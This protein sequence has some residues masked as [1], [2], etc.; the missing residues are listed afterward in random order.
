[1]FRT[2]QG[3]QS[4]MLFL[5]FPEKT[6]K[7]MSWWL[8]LQLT[9]SAQCDTKWH[10]VYLTRTVDVHYIAYKHTFLSGTYIS[11]LYIWEDHFPQKI[12]PLHISPRVQSVDFHVDLWVLGK[13]TLLQWHVESTWRDISPV[14]FQVISALAI[15]GLPCGKDS[16]LNSPEIDIAHPSQGL[17]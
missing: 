15:Q 4:S 11:S 16:A 14:P 13:K 10:T 1:M 8:Y 7:T 6:F 2:E 9:L 17:R 12:S 5:D 3:F